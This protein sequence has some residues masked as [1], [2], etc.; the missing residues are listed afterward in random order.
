MQILDTTNY[1]EPFVKIIDI[2]IL[3]SWILS[4]IGNAPHKLKRCPFIMSVF[5]FPRHN[6]ILLVHIFHQKSCLAKLS[7]KKRSY[8]SGGGIEI[9][10]SSSDSESAGK[11]RSRNCSICSFILAP[12]HR[13][14]T[15][16]CSIS[17]PL[18]SKTF[19]LPLSVLESIIASSLTNFFCPIVHFSIPLFLAF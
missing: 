3:E 9:I 19:V 8:K 6:C 11:I 7:Q 18:T 1:F 5:T 12:G 2:Q 14:N 15:S 16:L 4:H 10:F 13:P 17:V